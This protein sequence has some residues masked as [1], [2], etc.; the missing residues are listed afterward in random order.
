VRRRYV[1]ALWVERVISGRMD[2]LVTCSTVK[3]VNA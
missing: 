2:V 1:S 3:N